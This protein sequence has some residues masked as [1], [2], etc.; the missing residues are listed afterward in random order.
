MVPDN[1]VSDERNLRVLSEIIST[2][3]ATTA[4]TTTAFSSSTTLCELRDIAVKCGKLNMGMG[5]MPVLLQ[6][7]GAAKTS[8]T[9]YMNELRR[10]ART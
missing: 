1:F 7:V 10:I 4:G 9:D 8:L 2:S 5:V 6:S 3:T